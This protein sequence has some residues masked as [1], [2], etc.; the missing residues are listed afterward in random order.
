MPEVAAFSF[1]DFITVSFIVASAIFAAVRGFLQEILRIIA[2]VLAILVTNW[3]Y[4]FLSPLFLGW[5]GPGIGANILTVIVPF[6]SLLVLFICAAIWLAYRISDK[7]KIPFNH[8][9]GFFWGVF[10]GGLILS[11][12]YLGIFLALGAN[13]EPVWLKN[14]RSHPYLEVGAG[15]IL[16]LSPEAF[17]KRG[18]ELMSQSK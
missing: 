4:P 14:S 17:A 15:W 3:L 10:R 2:W 1:I 18:R 9:L 11:V 5:V 13:S 12:L 7:V 8:I 6:I 16:N